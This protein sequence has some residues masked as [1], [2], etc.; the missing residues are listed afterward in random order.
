M[1]FALRVP[2]RYKLRSLSEVVRMNENTPGPKT[3][4]YF[5]QTG[6]GKLVLRRALA[7]Y[8]P[9]EYAEGAKQGF[10][11]PDASWFKGE[12]IDYIR[13]L[14]CSPRAR[15]YDFIEPGTAQTLLDDHFTGRENRRLLIWSLLCFE[16]WCRT[17]LGE[18]GSRSRRAAS[19]R[20]DDA[21][22]FTMTPV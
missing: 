7:R 13:D 15:I 9:S 6:D 10:S 16:W 21:R 3:E 17:F 2:V 20:A 11:A 19:E 22:R 12:S 18:D 8:V 1:D 4:R 5:N 14:L